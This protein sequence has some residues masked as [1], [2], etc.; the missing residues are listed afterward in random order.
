[1]L[2]LVDTAIGFAVVMLMLSLLITAAVQAISALLDLRGRNLAK[3][4]EMLVDQICPDLRITLANLPLQAGTPAPS[5]KEEGRK[6]SNVIAEAVVN[7]PALAQGAKG[8]TWLT[9]R[10][11][12]IRSDEIVAVLRDLASDNSAGQ[13]DKRTKAALKTFVDQRVDRSDEMSQLLG[14]VQTALNNQHPQVEQKL[15]ALINDAGAKVPRLEQGVEQWF[16]T[17]MSRSSDVFQ[18]TARGITIGAAVLLALLV[19]ID[20]GRILHQLY[21]NADVRNSFVKMAED[22]TRRADEILRSGVRGTTAANELNQQEQ[23]A[24]TKAEDAQKQAREKSDS[25]EERKARSEAL[26]HKNNVSLFASIPQSLTTCDMADT[27]LAGEKLADG[28]AAPEDLR[29]KLRDTCTEVTERDL[30]LDA[31]AMKDLTDKLKDSQLE[32]VGWNRSKP[33]YG[34]GERLHLLGISAS[35]VLLS[36]G[37]PFWFNALRQLTNLKPTLASNIA[38]E[39]AA[40]KTPSTPGAARSKAKAAGAS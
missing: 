37:A 34:Y 1:M 15:A 36:F 4:V 7:H 31:T 22:V 5:A 3:H 19:Q 30:K 14:Q 35:I 17:V 27:W 6:A 21:T 20:S 25:D 38:E 18:R 26:A 10:A 11:K 8:V 12:A 24:Q 33:W 39:E 2:Q 28:T 16:D 13:L 40:E 32:I 29:K 23:D 9:S